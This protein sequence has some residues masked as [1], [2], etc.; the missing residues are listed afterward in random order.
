MRLGIVIMLM[1][2]AACGFRG[3]DRRDSAGEIGQLGTV[4][5]TTSIIGV[6]QERVTS[7]ASRL[8]GI[9]SPVRVHEVSGIKLSQK[10]LLN[11]NAARALDRWVD[12]G[13]KPAIR[14]IGERLESLRVVAH[15]TCRTRNNQKGGR[16]SEHG[17]GNAIDVAGCRLESGREITI[18]S[19]WGVGDDGRALARMRRA[20]CGPFGVVL[21]PGSDRFHNDHFHMDVSNLSRKYCR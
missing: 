9:A 15:Y 4:C 6:P 17:K 7:T 10:P 19:D 16:I 3:S 14:D 1:V 13:A 18:L 2:L 20:A 8:C 21:G 5:G 11:C 12:Q